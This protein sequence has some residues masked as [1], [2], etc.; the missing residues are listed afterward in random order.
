MPAPHANPPFKGHLA[1]INKGLAFL[2]NCDSLTLNEQSLCYIG[3]GQ[4]QCAPLRYR[5]Y[6]TNGPIRVDLTKAVNRGD[7]AES[8]ERVTGVYDGR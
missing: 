6:S 7:D 3:L 4:A 1:Q 8:G 5:A 2:K